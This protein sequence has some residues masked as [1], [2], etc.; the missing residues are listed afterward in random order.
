MGIAHNVCEKDVSF[1]ELE[2]SATLLCII[3]RFSDRKGAKNSRWLI[4]SK[5]LL[6]RRLGIR[7]APSDLVVF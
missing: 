2:A 4:M 7:V 6:N 1:L 5:P 3:V